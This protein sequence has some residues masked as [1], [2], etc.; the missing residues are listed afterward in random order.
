MRQG[1][2]RD[3]LVLV[4]ILALFA[5]L[6]GYQIKLPGLYYDEALD[7]VP[8]MQILQGQKVELVRQ[9]GI[10]LGNHAF[11]LMAMDY[12]G[13]VNTYALLPFFALL[14]VKVSSLRLLPIAGGAL[15][16]ILTYLLTKELFR[17]NVAIVSI[18]LLAV[19]PSFVFWTRQ[20]I[21]VTSLMSVLLMGSLLALIRWRRQRRDSYL[22]LAS[23]LLGLGLSSKI[24]FL[25]FIIALGLIYLAVASYVS[26][27]SRLKETE[28]NLGSHTLSLLDHNWG[29]WAISATIFLA[30]A[31][32]ILIYNIKT[33]GTLIALS[34]NLGTTGYGVSNSNF[35][36]NL[37]TRLD[38]FKVLIEGNFFWYLGGI[39]SAWLYPGAFG[40]AIII[41]LVIWLARREARAQGYEPL[42]LLGFVGLVVIQSM[43]TISDLWATHFYSLL[44]LAA[45]I[46]ALSLH[47]LHRFVPQRL[48]SLLWLGV[49]LFL[50]GQSLYVDMQYHRALKETGG[51][52]THSDAIYR[53][54]S[55]LEERRESQPW[56]MDW[57]IQ[58]SVVILTQGRVNP[59]EIFQYAPQP[60]I[61]FTNWLY[62]AMANPQNLYLFHSGDATV[63][64][65]YP[66]F[67]A[68]ARQLNKE[69]VLEKTVTERDG[70]PLFLVYSV[71]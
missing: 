61:N 33:R 15:T 12:V 24:L 5:I 31:A 18:L 35:F 20:G 50:F 10:R 17:R 62:G 56:V 23:L 57:G 49:I 29:P 58:K 55:Y 60:D 46:M 3:V 70:T 39:F 2:F 9:G 41:I 6:T 32:M 69:I 28:S 13:A 45:M 47:G 71:K 34:Q 66:A 63:F 40:A 68:M 38:N 53:L 42:L 16:L 22:Y 4:A 26:R 48:P 21:Y 8:A 1:W 67:E 51:R 59:V 54:A 19:H 27:V 25:W 14:G 64:P 44:P 65:R 11:P 52:R 30:G 36:A 43:V 7:A 37:T